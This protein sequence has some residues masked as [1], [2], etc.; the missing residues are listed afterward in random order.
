MGIIGQRTVKPW[1][2]GLL[3]F[4]AAALPGQSPGEAFL[5]EFYSSHEEWPDSFQGVYPVY[6]AIHFNGTFHKIMG[7]EVNRPYFFLDGKKRFI[8]SSAEI[9]FLPYPAFSHVVADLVIRNDLELEEG[10]YLSSLN[11]PDTQWKTIPYLEGG[12]KRALPVPMEITPDRPLRKGFVAM[13]FHDDHFNSRIFWQQLGPI[14]AG[15]VRKVE[16]VTD[17]LPRDGTYPHNFVLIFTR[18][19]EVR[20]QRRLEIN[21][22]LAALSFKWMERFISS[23][24][25]ANSDS[26]LPVLPIYQGA[27]QFLLH[28]GEFVSGSAR[29]LATVDRYGFPK[30]LEVVKTSN[31]LLEGPSLNMIQRWLFFP[32]LN[33]NGQ[34]EE[35]KVMVPVI[36]HPKRAKKS[37]R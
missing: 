11:R 3:I 32:K 5:S 30:N 25:E 4:G 21:D 12:I 22:S 31:D 13:V 7:V 35:S 34:A 26:E 6:P 36:Y 18:S 1:V 15:E 23:Y 37:G 9:T 8:H 28:R 27:A 17:P 24:V 10:E 19:G 2:V 14:K 29:V 16:L 33:N 20:T